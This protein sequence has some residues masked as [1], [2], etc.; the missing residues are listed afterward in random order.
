M[1]KC[2]NYEIYRIILKPTLNLRS[3]FLKKI[4]FEIMEE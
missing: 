1:E 2:L 3:I 4:T